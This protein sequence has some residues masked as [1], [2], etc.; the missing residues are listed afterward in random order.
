MRDFVSGAYTLA[1]ATLDFDPTTGRLTGASTSSVSVAVP[2]G[3]TL[4]IDMADSSQ[5]AAN[6]TVLETE[7]DGNPASE[8]DRVNIS[9]EGIV[10]AVF[11]NGSQVDVYQIPL[12]TVTSIDKLRPL[13]GNVYAV[14]DD[15]GNLQV[16]LPGQA[17]LGTI[18]SGA[19]EQSNVD[20]ANEL[21]IMIEAQN[22]YTANSKVFQT[23]AELMDVLVNLRR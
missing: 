6:Y 9:K 21:T 14:G 3:A 8:V 15:S 7:V 18:V 13:P 10:S 12:G 1:T 5:F 19:L 2:N 17:G 4:D 20:L 11:K 22:S 23:G 16:K